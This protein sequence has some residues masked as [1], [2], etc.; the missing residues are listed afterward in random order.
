MGGGPKQ[1]GVDAERVPEMLARIGNLDLDFQGFHIFSGS[2]NLRADAI[3]EAQRKTM[4]LALRL[5]VDAPA[6]VRLLNIGGGF[7]IPYFPG[8]QPLD[9][10]AVGAELVRLLD[11]IERSFP[12]RGS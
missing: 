8:E 11:G 12:R 9:I 2:Q 6:P 10:G 7:G 1:F 3:A 5:A 4:E